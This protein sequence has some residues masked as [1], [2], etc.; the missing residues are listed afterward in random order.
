MKI[1]DIN[2]VTNSKF[3]GNKFVPIN[4]TLKRSATQEN[5]LNP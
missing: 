1:M 4:S 5:N 2:K 3:L